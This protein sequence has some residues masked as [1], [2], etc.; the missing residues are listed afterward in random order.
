MGTDRQGGIEEG[1]GMRSFQLGVKQK[2]SGSE[3]IRV[4]QVIYPW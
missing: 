1:E 3:V 2:N 4:G